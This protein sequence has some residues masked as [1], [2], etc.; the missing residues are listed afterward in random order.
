MRWS[1]LL[2][3]WV[4][5]LLLVTSGCS[6]ATGRTRV[7]QIDARAFGMHLVLYPSPASNEFRYGAVRFNGGDVVT[8][9]LLQPTASTPLDGSNQAVRQLD[10]MVSDYRARHVEP[11]IVLGGTPA[12]AARSCAHGSW[13]VETCAPVA[14]GARS[15]WATYVHFLAMRYRGVSFEIWN[16][17][18]LRNGYN[19]DVG[20]LAA[21]QRTAAAII[22]HD[23]PRALVVSPSLAVTA[24]APL[25]WLRAFLEAPGGTAFDVVGVHLY[26]SDASARAGTGPE[27]SITMLTQVQDLLR[28]LRISRPIWDTEVNVGRYQYRNTTS[29]AFTGADG[30]AMVARTYL[31]QL[32]HGVQRVY[33]YAADDLQ[34]AGTWLVE[35]DERTVTPAGAAFNALASLLVGAEPRGCDGGGDLAWSCRFG[36]PSGQEIDAVWTTAGAVSLPLPKG[37]RRVLDVFGRPAPRLPRSLQ[38]SAV[39]QYIVGRRSA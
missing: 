18:N 17:P 28:A 11:L 26:P 24:G 39:P 25:Q 19:D 23:S 33:W 34:W 14:Y 31:L 7:G 4:G 30:A 15:P 6:Q 9:P 12:W 35:P 37:A 8:W 13:P 16:E 2:L 3:A 1:R 36:L 27:W 22:H 29:R 38:L 5:L 21:M 32:D 20:V 10:K